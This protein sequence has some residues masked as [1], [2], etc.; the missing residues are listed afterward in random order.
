MLHV[1]VG[2][3]YYRR[4][5]GQMAAAA[6]AGRAAEVLDWPERETC[7]R[8]KLEHRKFKTIIIAVLIIIIIGC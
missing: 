8:I 7:D 1:I 5:D 6:C 3:G 4:V 2:A